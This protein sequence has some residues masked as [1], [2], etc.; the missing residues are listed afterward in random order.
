MGW[1]EQYIYVLVQTKKKKALLIYDYDDLKLQHTESGLH[2]NFG[3]LFMISP[4]YNEYFKKKLK[5]FEKTFQKVFNSFQQYNEIFKNSD[6]SE[7]RFEDI[8]KKHS[9]VH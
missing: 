9:K 6:L 7:E 5:I 1:K 8:D 3:N 4:L 2:N